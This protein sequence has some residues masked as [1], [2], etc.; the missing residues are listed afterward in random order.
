M[1]I[2]T[3]DFNVENQKVAELWLSMSDLEA[4]LYFEG[5]RLMVIDKF[6]YVQKYENSA[7]K[8]NLEN[9]LV[10]LDDHHCR[11]VDLQLPV[12]Y[13]GLC[14]ISHDLCKDKFVQSCM[15]MRLLGSTHLLSFIASPKAHILIEQ[16]SDYI[17]NPVMAI[18]QF[19]LQNT[20]I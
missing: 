4:C 11:G 20:E 8:D 19:V 14:T 10:Y 9:C 5:N 15:R 2:T 7:F 1:E 6:Q 12:H 17:N 18:I 3:Y 16:Q 13:K